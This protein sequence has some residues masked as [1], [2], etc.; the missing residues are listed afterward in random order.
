MLSDPAL[1]DISFSVDGEVVAACRVLIMARQAATA[2]RCL[3]PM[4]FL[5]SLGLTEQS[6]HL[7]RV[8]RMLRHDRSATARSYGLESREV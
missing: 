8:A 3:S 1:S 2:V 7:A 6:S 5:F 4:S